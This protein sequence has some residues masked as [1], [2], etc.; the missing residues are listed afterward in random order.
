MNWF[1]DPSS[2]Y[3]VALLSAKIEL[4]SRRAF[5]RDYNAH[6]KT[7]DYADRR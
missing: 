7:K 2:V 4:L 6:S 1:L 5:I 3:D